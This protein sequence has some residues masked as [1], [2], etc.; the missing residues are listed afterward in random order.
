MRLP[1]FL[2]K[3]YHLRFWTTRT[4]SNKKDPGKT[5]DQAFYC[6]KCSDYRFLHYFWCH[7]CECYY[8][9]KHKPGNH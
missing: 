8:K 2:C 3:R 6:S 9:P 7:L 4:G 5:F 1:N